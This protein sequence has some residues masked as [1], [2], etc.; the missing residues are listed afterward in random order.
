[1]WFIKFLVM[2]IVLFIISLPFMIMTYFVVRK[3]EKEMEKS[4][5]RVRKELE[6]QEKRF[7]DKGGGTYEN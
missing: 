3:S 6:K 1:M 4:V 7:I 2:F 5:E